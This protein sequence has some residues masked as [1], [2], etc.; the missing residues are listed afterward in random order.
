[1]RRA[2]MSPFA[3]SFSSDCRTA[4]AR[5]EPVGA[6]STRAT[7]RVGSA[8]LIRMGMAPP[9]APNRGKASSDSQKPTVLA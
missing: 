1:M 8:W 6:S 3:C 4:A 7:E 5:P 9:S 2:L